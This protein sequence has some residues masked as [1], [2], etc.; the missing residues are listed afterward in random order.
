MEWF[1]FVTGALLLSSC[2]FRFGWTRA[3]DAAP[4]PNHHHETLRSHLPLPAQATY[5][6]ADEILPGLFLGNEAA[7]ADPAFLRA[8]G[9]RAI[10]A[11]S[12]EHGDR[13]PLA[14]SL[15]IQYYNF[16]LWDSV[17]RYDWVPEMLHA[18]ADRIHLLVKEGAGPVL[19]H[20]QMG[21][22]RSTTGLLAYMLKY[23]PERFPTYAAAYAVVRQA[24]PIVKPNAHFVRLLEEEFALNKREEL[25]FWP[26]G[27]GTEEGVADMRPISSNVMARRVKKAPQGCS[28]SYS[29]SR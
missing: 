2:V 17:Y 11:M 9:I 22:S 12:R 18:A 8:H 7:A 5:R 10:V 16:G 27:L 25:Y 21:M 14:E 29:G 23:Q 26:E 28:R 13:S 24:R 20:C 15:G 1:L 4:S 6:P 19:V 3:E